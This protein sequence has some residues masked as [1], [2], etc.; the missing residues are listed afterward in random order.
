MQQEMEQVTREQGENGEQTAQKQ[1]VL[2]EA[3]ASRARTEAQKPGPSGRPRR[4]I[5][6]F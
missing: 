5:N 6:P 2:Q 3:L 4:K 1:G